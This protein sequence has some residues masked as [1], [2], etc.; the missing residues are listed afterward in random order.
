M[1]EVVRAKFILSFGSL[2]RW[3]SVTLGSTSPPMLAWHTCTPG[4][5]G[6]LVFTSP[7]GAYRP[8]SRRP[9][10]NYPYPLAWSHLVLH[11]H[12]ASGWESMELPIRGEGGPPIVQPL[13]R[14]DWLVHAYPRVHILRAHGGAEGTYTSGVA[15]CLQATS[16]GRA[17]IGYGEEEILGSGLGRACFAAYEPDG[18]AVFSFLD[19]AARRGLPIPLNVVAVNLVDDAEAWILGTGEDS[20]LVRMNDLSITETWIWSNRQKSQGPYGS[21]FSVAAERL[22]ISTG[23]GP[24]L[25][26]WNLTTKQSTPLVAFGP[27]G[28][29]PV[30]R[31]SG[32]GAVLYLM[33]WDAA[34][35][36]DVR[37]FA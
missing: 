2:P 12:S 1:P 15:R 31:A 28:P 26:L 25:H 32:R 9:D 8:A 11:E 10:D 24:E 13:A 4:Y 5:D 16:T 14:G 34:Y 18:T 6:R 3:P 37:E 23:Q 21:G 22:L 19:V 17:W 27:E 29:L 33:T 35:A 36:L 30:Q 20:I 7:G